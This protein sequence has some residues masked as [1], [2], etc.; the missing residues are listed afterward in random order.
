MQ[1]SRCLALQA[2]GL[3][4]R[5]QRE[6]IERTYR[7]L[8]KV[9]HPDRF[10]S[11]PRLSAEA[12]EKLKSINSAYAFLNS[13]A[14]EMRSP[15]MPA[16]DSGEDQPVPEASVVN[17][18]IPA[19]GKPAPNVATFSNLLL[20]LMIPLCV[21][22]VA[23]VALVAADSYLSTNPETE[24]SYARFK[25]QLR[26]T[27]A[28]AKNDVLNHVEGKWHSKDSGPPSNPASLPGSSASEQGKTTAQDPAGEGNPNTLVPVQMPA[29][30]MPFVTVGLSRNEVAGVMGMPLSSTQ[31]ELAYRGAHFYLR[32]NSVAGW[33]IDSP[34]LMQHVRLFPSGRMDPSLKTF[35]IGSSRNDVIALQGTP[36]LLTENK[37]AYGG[38]EVFLEGGRVVGW[39]DDHASTRLRVAPH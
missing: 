32:N 12:D 36:T 16:S 23:A 35:G 18:A 37:L 25:S 19:T 3:D 11:D 22:I 29:I 31:S 21:L 24:S 2:L 6:D 7:I 38:S 30:K 1:C 10:Q 15:P 33:R 39:N 27:F 14:G 20:R 4:A 5:A 28:V 26:Y 9:W 34:A 17:A 8:V 13:P